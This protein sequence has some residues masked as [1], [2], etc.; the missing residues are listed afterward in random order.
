MKNNAIIMAAGFGSRFAPL[1][2]KT[3]K[4]LL[5]V[6]GENLTE[7]QILQ[8][9]EKGVEEI[10]IVTGH[11]A[12]QF[13]YLKEKYGVNII[14][15]PD[16]NTKNN[17]ASLYHARKYLRNTY[18]LCVDNYLTINP[19]TDKEEHS[20]YTI[21]YTNIP[22]NE[23]MV[24]LDENDKIVKMKEFGTGYYVLGTAYFNSE[25]SKKFIPILE[26]AYSDNSKSQ[27]LWEHLLDQNID[28]LDMRAKYVENDEVLEFDNLD[29]L[30]E[31]DEDYKN[32]TGDACF[33]IIKD[34]FKVEEKDIKGCD[35]KYIDLENKLFCFE[36][37]NNN[38]I[39]TVSNLSLD[40]LINEINIR[41]L[42]IRNSI[43]IENVLY[44]DSN[45]N[46][47]II[48]A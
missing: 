26:Q 41:K 38:Y 43:S 8:L 19:Y 28:V 13:E 6:K 34:F 30:R 25:F 22:I 5:N 39:F 44:Y 32:N 37:K 14:F 15:N 35:G 12:E 36:T 16:Y 10:H 21:K 4:G 24:T 40:R 31:F 23:Y 3:H 29:E 1:S 17:F 45:I 20:W 33:K 11:M 46:V 27:C 9:R 7:R 18:I 2:F 47:S 48:R 42:F